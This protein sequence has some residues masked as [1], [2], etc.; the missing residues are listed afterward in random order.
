MKFHATVK[1]MP[2]SLTLTLTLCSLTLPPLTLTQTSDRMLVVGE[3]S[4]MV[5]PIA[6]IGSR[7]TD[8]GHVAVGVRVQMSDAKNNG[9]RL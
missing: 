7:M 5:R 2:V 6:V 4:A 3:H 8:A 1:R 9:R